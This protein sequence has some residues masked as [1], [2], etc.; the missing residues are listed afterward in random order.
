M[1][2][3]DLTQLPLVK[4]LVKSRWPQFILQATALSGFIFAI[5]AGLFGTPVGSHNF[6]IVFVWIVWCVKPR[7]NRSLR[8]RQADRLA[9]KSPSVKRFGSG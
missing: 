2:R 6:S 1:I 4:A 9:N 8:I 7:I 3:Y 5:V